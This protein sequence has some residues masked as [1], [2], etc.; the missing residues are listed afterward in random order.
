MNVLIVDDEEFV[1]NYVEEQVRW[2]DFGINNVFRA[3]SA[4]EALQ[5]TEEYTIKLVI[6]DIRMPEK[7]GLELLSELRTQSPDS[8]VILLSGYSDFQYARQ[9]IQYGAVDYLLKPVTPEEL[10]ASVNK[11]C[12]FIAQETAM[13]IKLDRAAMTERRNMLELREKTLLELILGSRYSAQSFANKLLAADLPDY[14]ETPVK[15]L[16]I[17]IESKESDETFMDFELVTYSLANMTE[18]TLFGGIN[19]TSTFWYCKDPHHYMIVLLPQELWHNENELRDKMINLQKNTQ[20]FLNRSVSILI[21]RSELFPHH[22]EA[23][24]QDSLKYFWK[25]IGGNTNSLLSMAVNSNQAGSRSL[26]KL[27]EPPSVLH[28][29]ESGQWEQV[30]AKLRDIFEELNAAALPSQDNILEVY[31]SLCSAFAY[32]S[33]TQGMGLSDLLGQDKYW[34]SGLLFQHVQQLED[35]SYKLIEQ[36]ERNIDV[37]TEAG[38]PSRII[39]QIHAFIDHHL[40]GDV[41]L[42]KIADHVYLHPVYLSRLY[43]KETG[44]SLSTYISR[45]RLEKA[46]YLLTHTNKKVHEI[47]KDIGYLKPQYFIKLFKEQ[48][49][50]TPQEFR[51]N[52]S[53][54]RRS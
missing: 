50:L 47:S 9:A 17:R 44:E 34:R 10:H 1:L 27:Y 31:Y 39:K 5:Y 28:L 52:I 21:S 45:I 2:E 35:W 38:K 32:I 11:A 37:H 18:E 43:K 40:S 22:L 29:M 33:N 41:S 3:S 23:L 48:N 19:H 24:Y 15:L 7:T 42:S 30:R 25:Y 6:T 26:H 12:A 14:T 53:G 54:T 49:L 8:K 20:L 36:F 13:K 4:L 16:I 51:E 46:A